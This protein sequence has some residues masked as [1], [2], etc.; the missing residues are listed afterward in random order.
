MPMLRHVLTIAET[1]VSFVGLCAEVWNINSFRELHQKLPDFCEDLRFPPDS[2]VF[3]KFKC[4]LLQILKCFEHHR[5]L[6][7][8]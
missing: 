5:P 6:G 2:S 7:I 3:S 4:D 8:A 1:F